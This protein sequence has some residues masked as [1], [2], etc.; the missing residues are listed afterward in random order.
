MHV[1]FLQHKRTRIE[2]PVWGDRDIRYDPFADV[3][4][5]AAQVVIL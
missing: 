1:D 4:I 5:A 2:L 3:E